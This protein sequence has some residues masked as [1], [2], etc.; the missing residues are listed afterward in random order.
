MVLW[1]LFLS[2]MFSTS[3]ITLVGLSVKYMAG[4]L[5][6]VCLGVM[7]L[8]LILGMATLL[9]RHVNFKHIPIGWGM[10]KRR[11]RARASQQHPR[12]APPT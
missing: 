10:L 9:G 4:P 3:V 11:W 7:F 8:S 12:P 2:L 6:Q 5:T 1:V